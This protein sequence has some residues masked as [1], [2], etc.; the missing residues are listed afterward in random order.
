MNCEL[1]G[2][3]PRIVGHYDFGLSNHILYKNTW[4]HGAIS[5]ITV[6][7]FKDLDVSKIGSFFQN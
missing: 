5:E 3:L 4:N 1:G 7:Y 6:C 2:S